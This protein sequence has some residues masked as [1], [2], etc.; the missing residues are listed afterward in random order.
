MSMGRNWYSKWKCTNCLSLYI[1]CFNNY[2]FK[3]VVNSTSRY[4]E[5]SHSEFSILIYFFSLAEE[6]NKLWHSPETLISRIWNRKLGH[7]PFYHSSKLSRKIMYWICVK[8]VIHKIKSGY[9]QENNLF[10]GL[11]SP[12][13]VVKIYEWNVYT[14]IFDE[15]NMN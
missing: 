12:L 11:W 15:I 10:K 1:I 5:D 8:L 14:V 6:F 13:K 9:F 7:L 3:Y 4:T 2:I